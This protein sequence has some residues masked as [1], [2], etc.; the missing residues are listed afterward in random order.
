MTE[1]SNQD[2]QK[3][4]GRDE[5]NSPVQTFA[6]FSVILGLAGSGAYLMADYLWRLG[7][8]FSSGVLWGLFVILFTY[9]S[10]GFTHA[11]FGFVLR[12]SRSSAGRMPA[13]QH[14]FEEETKVVRPRVAIIIP[15][16]NEP[17]GRVFDGIRAIFD[18]V[19][20]EKDS[21]VF[22]FFIL[23]D[24]ADPEQWLAEEEAWMK[25]NQERRSGNRIFY[26]HRL[27][28]VGKK[29]G[30][31]SDF[32]RTWADH[33][34]YMI[35]LDADSVM[36]GETLVELYWRME[37]NPRVGLIQTAP[38]LVGGESIFGRMQQFANRLY[39][40]GFLEGLGFWSQ[41]GGNF[42][43]HNA[44]IR[45]RPFIEEC[46]LPQLPGRKPF[47]GH[48]LSHDFVEAGLLRRAG[49]E[50][51][52]VHDLPGSYEEGPQG[53]IESAQ[54]DQRWCQGN[55]QHGLLLFARGLR[56]KTRIHLAN[57]IMGYLASPLWLL[58]MSV[59]FAKAF[60]EGG[61]MGGPQMA[62]GIPLLAFT[63]CLL[64]GPKVLAVTE[65]L[66]NRDRRAQ[67]GG[68]LNAV[69][70]A[71][72]ETFFSALIAP[73]MMMFHSKF[74][75]WNLVGR[76]V[77]WSA[78][79]RGAQGTSWDQAIA[80]HGVHTLAGLSVGIVAAL[81]NPTLFWWLS[82]V[83]FGLWVSI[84]FSVWTS[85]RDIGL[86]LKREDL[87]LIPEEKDPPLEL[88][89][90]LSGEEFAKN[91]FAGVTSAVLDPFVNA[92][93][94]SLLRRARRRLVSGQRVYSPE[95]SFRLPT[96]GESVTRRLLAEKLL[97]EGPKALD[98]ED[99]VTVLSDIDS[100]LWMHREAWMRPSR[101]LSPWWE[102]AIRRSSVAV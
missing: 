71:M 44:I 12:M 65:L 93:H 7:W 86:S 1:A 37:A 13:A 91:P 15:I 39:G 40:P 84:P 101:Q 11:A 9:L 4:K 68:F 10:F 26:R 55:L 25:L 22:D 56:G 42:W 92:V 64:F 77:E 95:E 96:E 34:R 21:D 2:S 3:P 97:K 38:A 78:Q 51:W 74:V 70:G 76:T 59:A 58:F 66:F 60:G 35:V 19:M 29:S 85:R 82:P 69:T 16:Y 49:W 6:F 20:R 87:F 32:C 48:I 94:I 99:T 36:L 50:V 33:Y 98:R 90:A 89:E 102:L 5:A 30:N 27:S 43:G 80:A 75:V 46:D 47:G 73:V 57:G 28:N 14:Q 100:M 88:V 23:S 41:C 54:R 52:L 24:S 61:G 79:R 83:L 72:V 18:S 17:V 67:F 31:V 45:L 63:F 8:D 53:I 81:S 62:G